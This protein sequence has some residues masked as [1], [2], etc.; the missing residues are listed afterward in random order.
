MIRL[1]SK[2]EGSTLSE[3]SSKTGWP[4]SKLLYT[5]RLIHVYLGHG[6]EKLPSGAYR[7]V[8]RPRDRKPFDADPKAEIK[9]YLPGTDRAKI[10]EM[11]SRP[12]GATLDQIKTELKIDQKKAYQSVKLINTFLGYGLREDDSGR[13]FLVTR[14]AETPGDD[15]VVKDPD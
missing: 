8:G 4:E 6:V 15:Q 1:M 7:L 3:M 13:I 12:E 5:I 14:E 2:P 9:D 10:I 11:L